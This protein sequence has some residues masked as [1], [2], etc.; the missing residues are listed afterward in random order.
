MLLELSYTGLSAASAAITNL[1]AGIVDAL[2]GNGGFC[3]AEPGA[4]DMA[5]TY[6]LIG[7]A[8]YNNFHEFTLDTF[9]KFCVGA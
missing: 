6:R 5:M 8:T 1:G 3:E 2:F 7:T 4:D 9:S